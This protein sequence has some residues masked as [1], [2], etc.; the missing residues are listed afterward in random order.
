MSKQSQLESEYEDVTFRC[1]AQANQAGDLTG[2]FS[3]INKEGI[4]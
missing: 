1:A 4:S 2:M 3:I